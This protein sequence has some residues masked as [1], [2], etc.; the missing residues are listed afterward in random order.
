MIKDLVTYSKNEVLGK[1]KKKKKTFL[2][3]KS[4]CKLCSEYLIFLNV[5]K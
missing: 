5:A 2:S 3:A 4:E 1:K